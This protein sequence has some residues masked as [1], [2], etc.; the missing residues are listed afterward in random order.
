MTQEQYYQG[1]ES[2]LGRLGDRIISANHYSEVEREVILQLILHIVV[3]HSD[4]YTFELHYGGYQSQ[5]I[6]NSLVLYIKTRKH[7]IQSKFP[8]N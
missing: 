8:S 3:C 7:Q 1:W 2:G 6:T 5:Q 4:N